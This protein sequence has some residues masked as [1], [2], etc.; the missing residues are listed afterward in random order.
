MA[1]Y[2][3]SAGNRRA[4]FAASPEG[5]AGASGVPGSTAAGPG[6]GTG[7][8]ATSSKKNDVPSGLYV[9]KSAEPPSSV[10]GVPADVKPAPSVNPNLMA[11]ARP[12]WTATVDFVRDVLRRL[13]RKVTTIQLKF[14]PSSSSVSAGTRDS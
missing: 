8:G 6:N 11:N 14:V 4:T 9:G 1:L 12:A 2:V 5:H 3:T 10:A 13:R 7:K